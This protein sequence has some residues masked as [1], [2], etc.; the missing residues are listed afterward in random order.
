MLPKILYKK[1]ELSKTNT[2]FSRFEGTTGERNQIFRKLDHEKMRYNPIR[3]RFYHYDQQTS[4]RK[5]LWHEDDLDTNVSF[6]F[7][8]LFFYNLV[9]GNFMKQVFYLIF[10]ICISFSSYRQPIRIPNFY[11]EFIVYLIV[12]YFYQVKVLN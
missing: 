4:L 1:C 9:Q 10:N 2:F 6:N 12:D 11:N 3:I 8:C 5:L 7:I